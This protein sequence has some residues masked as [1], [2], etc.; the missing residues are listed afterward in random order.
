MRDAPTTILVLAKEPLPGRVK[1]RLCS[2]FSA[3]EAAQLAAAALR[4]TLDAVLRA[5]A[6]RRVLMLDGRPGDWVPTG[7]EVLPQCSGGLDERIADALARASG[8]TLLIGMDTPQ[9]TP[10]QLSVRWTDH[11]A[12]FGPSDDGGFWA[13]GMRD[14]HPDLVLGVPMSTSFTG[15]VQLGRLR[16]AGLGVGLLPQLCDVD[17]PACAARVAALAPHTHF[18]RTHAGM[19][20]RARDVG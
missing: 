11:D 7:I 8:P 5:P 4:D 3:V 19:I 14:P 12:W 1:T 16:D 2:R 10:R 9:V 15:A 18:A 13:L 6:R 17:T 20:G